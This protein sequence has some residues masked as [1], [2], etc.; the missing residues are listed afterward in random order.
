MCGVTGVQQWQH[1]GH[2]DWGVTDA[3]VHDVHPGLRNA[4][5]CLVLRT[6]GSDTSGWH[7]LTCTSFNSE[8]HPMR[9]PVIDVLAEVAGVC[10]SW[11]TDLDAE[12]VTTKEAGVE[13]SGGAEKGA[14]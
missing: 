7:K 5:T 11:V 14:T 8:W 6:K 1:I 12:H 10:L 4:Q 3:T 2:N 13:V 9:S